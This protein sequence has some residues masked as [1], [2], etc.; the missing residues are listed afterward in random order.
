MTDR[1][2]LETL[3]NQLIHYYKK[4]I[5]EKSD[6]IPTNKTTITPKLVLM[7]LERYLELGGSLSFIEENDMTEYNEFISELNEA[8]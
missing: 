7:T 1:A 4:G 2:V 3:R 8:C 6:L 5:G